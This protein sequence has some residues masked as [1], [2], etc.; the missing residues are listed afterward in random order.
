MVS[1]FIFHI[2]DLKVVPNGNMM[3]SWVNSFVNRAAANFGVIGQPEA[4][5]ICKGLFVSNG[6]K[7]RIPCVVIVWKELFN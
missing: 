2:S 7:V 6:K 1:D 5:A 3:D 4:P